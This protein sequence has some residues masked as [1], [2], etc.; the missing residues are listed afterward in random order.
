[1]T[2]TIPAVSST[3]A[4]LAIEAVR[5]TFLTPAFFLP[6]ELPA[7]K[8]NQAM[9]EDKAFRGLPFDVYDL[10]PG[11][12]S[13]EYPMKGNVYLDTLPALFRLCLGSA[14]TVTGSADP[15]TH[16]I[17]ALTTGGGTGNQ[18]PSA[19]IVDFDGITA[20]QFIAAQMDSLALS[21]AAD[22]LMTF[23]T[24]FISN[25]FTDMGSPP[26]PSFSTVEAAPSWSGAV[27]IDSAVSTDIET[28]DL[29]LARGAKPI[30]TIGQQG[31]RRNWAGPITTSGKFTAIYES[32]A[33]LN[34][35]LAGASHTLTF[36]FTPP[37]A[38]THNFTMQYSS[39][40]LKTGAL[41]RGKDYLAQDFEFVGLPNATDAVAGM[42]TVKTT[43]LNAHTT[44][45]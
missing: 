26:V 21:F 14:D 10:V 3:W 4:G 44:A 30:P 2:D 33:L 9:L 13:D 15:Y 16:V 11:I 18:P 35:Y 17:G 23:D 8:A 22:A 24:K 7:W 34:S 41:N 20:R 5:G 38:P 19:S 6:V 32:E 29:T 40:K 25:P 1:M 42:G 45:Y 12:R 31:P 27:T 43:T 37:S 39:V 28:A 36:L